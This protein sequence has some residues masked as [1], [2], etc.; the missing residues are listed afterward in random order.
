VKGRI[1][2]YRKCEVSNRKTGRRCKWGGRKDIRTE[3][4]RGANSAKLV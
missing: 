4:E 1:A 3:G 2:G